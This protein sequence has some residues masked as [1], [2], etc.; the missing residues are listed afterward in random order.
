M[1]M[2]GFGEKSINNLLDAIENSKNAKENLRGRAI[3]ALPL[4][5]SILM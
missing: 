3:N 2:E 4:R 5:L 1:T